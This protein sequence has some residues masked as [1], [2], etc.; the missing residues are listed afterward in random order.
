[1]TLGE[2]AAILQNPWLCGAS[3][4][5]AVQPFL[6]G[7]VN[8]A[9]YRRAPALDAVAAETRA[10]RV[11]VCIPARNEKANIEACV[12]SVLASREVDVRAYVYDDES[13]DGT[14]E[15]VAR[16]AAEDPRVVVVPRRPLPAGWNGKQH[17]CFRMAEHGLGYDPALEWFLFTDA[18]VRLEPDAVARALGFA[19][20]S[21]SSLVSTV[22]RE[23]TGTFGE[24]L[25]VPLIHF[26]LMSYL[27][28]GRMRSTLDPAASA[29]C[30]Q[31]ILVSRAAYRAA[32][33]G[34][35]YGHA[36]FKDSMHDGVKFPRAVRRAGL[37][38]DLYDGTE[39]V[40]CRMYRGFG[41][42]WRGFAK[43]AFEGLGSVGLLVFIT[44]YHAIGQ[45]LP[46]IVVLLALVA[47]QWS[48]GATL[49]AGAI[50]CALCGRAL[51]AARF[52]Q[53]WWS[54][55]LHLPSILAL[56]AVQWRSLWLD[57]T[58]RRSWKGRG[59]AQTA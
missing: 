6:L 15:I 7:I 54:I 1:M 2:V 30:G 9:R 10:L 3:L 12:R 28:I 53:S 36:G 21:K 18:D 45:V 24:M 58:G 8:M 47:A 23:I 50:A 31:F 32:G 4:V 42:T 19:L 33:E 39:S 35:D 26:V 13:T 11:A 37:R 22:P 56:S 29:A 51:L 41:E 27:P 16:L 38:T 40:S 5:A 17:A 25:L 52:R 34:G 49:A 14:G 59:G 55:A 46:W 48:T 44:V 57:R 20:R 43:N